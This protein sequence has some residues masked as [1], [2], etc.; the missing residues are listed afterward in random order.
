MPARDEPRSDSAQRAFHARI[1]W[2]FGE[3]EQP[4]SVASP[5]RAIFNAALQS[6]AA[7]I[8]RRAEVRGGT[9]T[10]SL[11][12]VGATGMSSGLEHL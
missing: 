11:A 8:S 2:W 4:M 5:S 1:L 7:P 3:S 10:N 9:A 12:P 6:Q